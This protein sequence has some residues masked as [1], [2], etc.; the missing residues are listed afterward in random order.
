MFPHCGV[1]RLSTL[2]TF[3]WVLSSLW[4]V[5]VC[6]V[7]VFATLTRLALSFP[8]H[9][10]SDA[11]SLHRFVYVLLPHPPPFLLCS[12]SIAFKWLFCSGPALASAF[13]PDAQGRLLSLSLPLL[14]CT[15]LVS[16]TPHFLYCD[17]LYSAM[18]YAY[19]KFLPPPLLLY[20]FL[21][22]CPL[23]AATRKKMSFSRFRPC[24]AIGSGFVCA[25][26]FA[27][28]WFCPFISRRF[29]FLF[30]L[31]AS[32]FCCFWLVFSM[33]CVVGV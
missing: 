15:T 3:C 33:C 25:V 21:T 22:H 23:A 27:I 19:V 7:A 26:W 16:S 32:M 13:T 29:S 14:I 28:V 1:V 20:S 11:C 17:L 4:F 2:L 9:H 24:R 8:T 31:F 18:N 30:G 12:S 5:H 6:G 10:P